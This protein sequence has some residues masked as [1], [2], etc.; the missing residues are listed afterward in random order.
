MVSHHFNSQFAIF[1][2]F[3]EEASAY[4]AS[5]LNFTTEA[6]ARSPLHNSTL[7]SSDRHAHS[8]LIMLC[9]VRVLGRM[10]GRS[11]LQALVVT[12]SHRKHLCSFMRN[13]AKLLLNL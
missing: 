3:T 9:R 6:F 1:P 11:T 8:A 7:P 2:R 5:R 12:L 10:R 13:T 4:V